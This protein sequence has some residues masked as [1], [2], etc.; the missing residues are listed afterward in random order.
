MKKIE[1]KSLDLNEL[2]FREDPRPTDVRRV[3]GINDSSDFFADDAPCSDDAQRRR[4]DLGSED[5]P[6][7]T[8]LGPRGPRGC[9]S[10]GTVRTVSR[11]SDTTTLVK[12]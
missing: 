10:S 9:P 4:I 8:A 6:I 3:R 7:T 2:T 11:F 5:H 12:A 1:G